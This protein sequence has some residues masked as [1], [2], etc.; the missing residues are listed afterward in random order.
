MQQIKRNV[1]ILTD[2][3]N[4]VNDSNNPETVLHRYNMAIDTLEKL[5]IFTDGELTA[6]GFHLKESLPGT[7]KR[8]RDNKIQLLNQ[9]ITRN[10]EHDI[11]SVVKNETKVKKYTAS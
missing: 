3:L 5:S 9:A 7:L 2:S 1:E 8:M 4:L 10:L 6:M 11:I